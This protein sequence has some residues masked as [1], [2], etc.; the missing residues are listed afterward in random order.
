MS[1]TII[2][3]ITFILILLIASILSSKAQEFRKNDRDLNLGA[4][5]GANWYSGYYWRTTIP[6][7]SASFDYGLRDDLGPGVIGIGGY[8]GYA[9][10]KTSYY[11]ADFGW[12]YTSILIGA[13]GTYHMT[14]TENLDTYAGIILGYRLESYKEYGNVPVGLPVE[15]NKGPLGDLFVGAKYYF[16]DNFALRGELGYGIT[17]LTVGVTFKL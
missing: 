12:K 9:G 7:L 14:F 16:T 3:H 10:Y 8:L 5:F 6:T 1:K 13:M 2:K 15:T 17:W 4:G 11:G